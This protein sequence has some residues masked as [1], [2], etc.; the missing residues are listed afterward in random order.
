MTDHHAVTA[1]RLDLIAERKVVVMA[2]VHPDGRPQLSLIRPRVD[3]SQIEVSLTDRRVKTR[4]L[5]LDPRCALIAVGRDDE[6]FVVVEAHATLT[7]TSRHPG[8]EVG[9]ELAALYRALAGEH[10]DWDNYYMAMVD[11]RRLIA[12]LEVSHSYDGGTHT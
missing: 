2:T 4:N 3:G 9:R 12:R 6:T 8:D 11:E 1:D 5:R 7:D 10:P